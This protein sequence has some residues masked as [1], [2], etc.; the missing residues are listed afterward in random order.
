MTQR[1]EQQALTQS[2][3]ALLIT[4]LNLRTNDNTTTDI[5]ESFNDSNISNTSLQ[6]TL[7]DQVYT[8]TDDFSKLVVSRLRGVDIVDYCLTTS[9]NLIGVLS[10]TTRKQAMTSPQEDS[11]LEAEQ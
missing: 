2:Y 10:P 1:Y 8:A 7:S 3:H 9:V 6:A 11:W 4:A 5:P